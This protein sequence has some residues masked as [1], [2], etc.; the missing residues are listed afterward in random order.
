MSDEIIEF[1]AGRILVLI[2]TCGIKNRITGEISLDGLTKF[3]KLDF[4]IRYPHHFRTASKH[5]GFEVDE[6]FNVTDSKMIRFHYGPWDDRYNQVLPYLMARGLLRLTMIGNSYTLTLPL[7]SVELVASLKKS[8]EFSDILKQTK[9]VKKVMGN[10][11]G[12]FLKNLI[13]E[14]FVDEVSNKSL[15]DMIN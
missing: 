14:L 7:Q 11:S 15:K 10:K 2:A 4:F 5:L 3:A 13:Y 8:I 1:H 6:N 12:S 9:A